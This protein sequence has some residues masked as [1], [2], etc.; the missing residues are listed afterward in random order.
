MGNLIR[1]GMK[2]DLD[3]FDRII[4]GKIDTAL[5]G[6]YVKGLELAASHH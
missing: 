6:S 5:Q 3:G 2:V 4:T 1:I